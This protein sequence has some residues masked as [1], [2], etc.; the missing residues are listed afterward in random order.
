MVHLESLQVIACLHISLT[1]EPG[2]GCNW[3]IVI[4]KTDLANCLYQFINIQEYKYNKI[5]STYAYSHINAVQETLS[6]HILASADVLSQL[7]LRDNEVSSQPSSTPSL[8]LAIS[9][10]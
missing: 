1:T 6:I 2:G 5:I 10:D 3:Y 7:L 8:E 4:F 9:S